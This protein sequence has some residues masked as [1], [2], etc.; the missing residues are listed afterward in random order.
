MSYGIIGEDLRF[1]VRNQYNIWLSFVGYA[2]EGEIK[3]WEFFDGKMG[4]RR[5]VY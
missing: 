5:G 1:Y 4:L 3:S 2:H